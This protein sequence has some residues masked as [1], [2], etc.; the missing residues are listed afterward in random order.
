[1]NISIIGAGYVGLV[2]G[3]GFA[4]KG[5]KVTCIDKDAKKVESINSGKSPIY[6]AGLEEALK[7]TV[8]KKLN[9]TTDLSKGLNESRVFFVCVGTP[10]NERGECHLEIIKDVAKSVGERLK[11][12][13]SFP[14]VVI[15]STVPPSTTQKSIV[16]LLESTSG[17]KAGRDFGVCV[18]P[19]FLKEGVALEDFMNPDRIVCGV[20]DKKTENVMKELYKGFNSPLFFTGFSEAEMIKYASNCFL[21]TKISFINE[22]GNLCKKLGINTFKVSEGIGLDKRISPHFLKPG[23]GFGGS[24]F[25]KDLSALI[26]QF[27]SLGISPHLLEGVA[28][29]NKEQPKKIVEIAKSKTELKGKKVGV[30]GLAFK[31]GTDDVRDSR[32]I[33]VI[34]ELQ[35]E[36]AELLLHD[37]KAEGNMKKLFPNSEFADSAQK[38]VDASDIIFI[39]TEWPQFSKL[40][41]GNKQ[42]FDGRNTFREKKP[43]KYEGVCW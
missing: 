5:H 14:I 11:R 37:P 17:K 19:E 18:N 4:L 16:P 38:L 15:K 24:C 2:S 3:V 12:K 35:K 42:V 8:P 33:Q 10:C 22:I 20:S 30:L 21:A 1:M 6:E 34:E 13:N 7:K 40:K 41:F 29:V 23:I 31:P 26:Y 39:L 36:G 9:A 25:P 43:K 28:K 27:R 32:S